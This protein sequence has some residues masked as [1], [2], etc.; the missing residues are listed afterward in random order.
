MVNKLAL[1]PKRAISEISHNEK[2][3][4][5]D[6]IEISEIDEKHYN[7][8]SEEMLTAKKLEVENLIKLY[9]K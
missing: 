9:I 3:Y 8:V 2:S 7:L 6:Q 5:G 1:S 4:N